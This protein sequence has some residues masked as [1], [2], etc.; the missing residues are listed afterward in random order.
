MKSFA[1]IGAVCAINFN[2][3]PGIA[4]YINKFNSP[5]DLQEFEML[6]TGASWALN[7][8]KIYDADGDG[9]EDNVKLTSDQL[10]NYFFPTV[11]N[12]SED[13]YNTRNGEYPGHLQREFYEGQAVPVNTHELVKAEWKKW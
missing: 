5:A 10:D 7:D 12:T 4:D 3:A 9:V 11:F 1:L 6:Q 13:L 8:N 2:A